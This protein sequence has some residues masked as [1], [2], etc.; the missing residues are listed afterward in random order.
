MYK[1]TKYLTAGDKALTIEYGNEISEDISSKVRSM[2]VAL[3]I[4]KID[5]I[6]EIVP[7]YRSLMVH[8]NPLIIGYDKLVNKVKSLENKLQDISLPEPEVIEIPTV[9]GGE[10]GPDIGNVAKHNKITVEEVVKI[11]SSKEYLIYMLGFTPGFPYLGGM[12]GKIATPRLKSPRTKIN[13]G[14]VGIAGSQTGIYPIDSPGG[15]QLIGKTPLK[16]YEPN[17]EVPILLK[18]GNYIKFVP[19][20]EGEYKSIEKAVN[21]GTYKYNTYIKKSGERS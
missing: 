21:N 2:M 17:R 11:H 7:T 16:L 10:Y 8:Y 3:E 19:I 14:S 9:Y 5:G 12:N 20:F 13:K 1:E 4:N 6:V 15:W 18:A